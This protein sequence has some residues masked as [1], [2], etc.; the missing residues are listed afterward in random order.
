MAC[1]ELFQNKF[2]LNN[3]PGRTIVGNQKVKDSDYLG[4]SI[5]NSI[6]NVIEVDGL[7]PYAVMKLIRGRISVK[8]GN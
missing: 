5:F 6:I 4:I 7:K 1:S 2:G 8:V 3:T